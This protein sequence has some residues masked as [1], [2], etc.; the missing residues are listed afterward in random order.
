MT[1]LRILNGADKTRHY[2]V[3][4][5][6]GAVSAVSD[7]LVAD[8]QKY[9]IGST[10]TDLDA[11]GKKYTRVAA[12]K[13][14]ADW[15]IEGYPLLQVA[16][17][18]GV[19][20]TAATLNAILTPGSEAITEQGFEYKKGSDAY[21]KVS[22]TEALTKALTG[23]TAETEYTFRAYAITAAGTIYSNTTTFTT[24]AA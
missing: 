7:A 21:T 1:N 18:T 10:Y 17:A 8:V 2:S 6:N 5:G 19:A 11:G 16:P 9:P 3:V 13:A 20:A 15:R 4:I 12:D 24:L 14:V 22:V 23:L